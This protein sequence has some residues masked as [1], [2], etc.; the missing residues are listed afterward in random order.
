MEPS[1]LTPAPAPK[2]A[3]M[4][5]SWNTLTESLSAEPAIRPVTLPWFM[6]MLPPAAVSTR[7]LSPSLPL[8]YW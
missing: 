1:A 2:A 3:A 8:M 5:L 4:P 6:E 7:A